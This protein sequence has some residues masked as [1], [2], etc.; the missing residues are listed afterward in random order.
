MINQNFKQENL[1]IYNFSIIA[2]IGI[3][4][5]IVNKYNKTNNGTMKMKPVDGK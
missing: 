4:A 2:Y 5:D 1:K 3:V